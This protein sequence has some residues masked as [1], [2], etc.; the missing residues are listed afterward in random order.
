MRAFNRFATLVALLGGLLIGLPVARAQTPVGLASLQVAFWPE[1]DQESVLVL[2]DGALLPD[3][4]LPATVTLTLP[5]EPLAVAEQATDGSLVNAQY[6]TTPAGQAFAVT[7]T[8]QQPNFRVEYYDP[9]LTRNGDVRTYAYSWQVPVSIGAATFRVQQPAGATDLKLPTEFGSPTPGEFGLSYYGQNLGALGAG[10]TI[11]TTFSY[12]K[13][14][15]ALTVD[16]IDTGSTGSSAQPT[17]E[18]ASVA[19]PAPDYTPWLASAAVALVA[20]VLIVIIWLRG[21]Q[22][23]EEPR[24]SHRRSRRVGRATV[25]TTRPTAVGPAPRTEAAGAQRQFCT[26][27]GEPVAVDDRFCRRCGAPVKTS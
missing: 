24:S 14:G 7:L 11:S 13:S 6:T 17:V 16:Q 15:S 19:T 25:E 27:C 18:V 22:E 23:P 5:V 20:I 26:Q 9:A 10:D 4:T 1:F 12:T 2:I 8:L 3:T 21:R